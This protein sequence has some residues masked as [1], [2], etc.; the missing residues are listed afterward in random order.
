MLQLF[1][2]SS[3][4]SWQVTEAEKQLVYPC[5]TYLQSA[6]EFL[7]RAVTISASPRVVFDWLC[8]LR[9]APYSYDW[10]D[11]AGKQSP[12]QKDPSLRKLNTRQ[13]FMQIFR[14]I[15]FRE[16]QHITL[17][18][19]LPHAE[20]M[21]GK[22]VGCYFIRPESEGQTRLIVKL[23]VKRSTHKFFSLLSALLPWG[24]W[25]MMRKQLLTI[26]E[27]AERGD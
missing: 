27:L 14:L 15:D 20:A 1:P 8:Q 18:T 22:I 11:N 3:A 9:V 17:E 2:N 23:R 10:I 16:D 19:F 21:F 6:D 12:R 25:I 4:Y 24:D 13:T 7:Y 26:K 5:D